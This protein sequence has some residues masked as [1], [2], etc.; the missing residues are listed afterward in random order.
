MDSR[1]HHK[2]CG[3]EWCR[4]SSRHTGIK[5]F[6][7]PADE[8]SRAWLQYARRQDLAHLPPHQIYS[9]Y[10]LCSAH[11]TS[12]D[13]ADPGQ[14]GLLRCAVPTVSIFGDGQ[15]HVQ[16]PGSRRPANTTAMPAHSAD[17]EVQQTEPS[18][19]N[20]AGRQHKPSR[21]SPRTA[22]KMKN[23][24][25]INSR[26]RK[27]LSR[28][29]K[30]K[31]CHYMDCRSKKQLI[32]RYHWS[33][34]P[35]MQR[36]RWSAQEDVMLLVAVKLYGDVSWS[37][38]ASMVPGRTHGQ[39]RDRYM[40]NFAQQFVLGPFTSDEDCTLLQLMQKYGAGHWAMAAR[41]MPWRA[42]NTLLMRYRRL[43]ETL[44]TKE[45]TV[46]DVER[47]LAVPVAPMTAVR[48]ARLT[49]MDKRMDLYRRIR[50]L[51]NTD[52]MKRAALSLVKCCTTS[53]ACRDHLRTQKL[54]KWAPCPSLKSSS[55]RRCLACQM[56]SRPKKAASC[57]RCC[58]PTRQR[59]L[60][61]GGCWITLTAVALWNRCL[62]ATTSFPS[63]PQLSTPKAPSTFAAPSACREA[64][65]RSRPALRCPAV[66]ARMCGPC[67]KVT[68]FCRHAS[69]HTFSGPLSWT[70]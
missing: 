36:G 26:L 3:A 16:S 21:C 22:R 48:C 52:V 18:C 58:R 13:Y 6:R 25:K 70:P 24:E 29:G 56:H 51:L 42:S 53:T 14:T 15:T 32:N 65:W 47:S 59:W 27:A 57:F 49:G 38:V 64:S 7:I 45:P 9:S 66:G 69:S 61:M 20:P 46:A 40:D 12:R 63:S 55:L 11:F 62:W 67:E 4:N 1:R 5:F 28:I 50:R 30:R 37:K 19:S 10:R 17:E 31:V 60:P 23:L 2:S 41:D 44:R 35:N 34:Y 39:C 33:L 54:R 8:R 43:Y 68:M